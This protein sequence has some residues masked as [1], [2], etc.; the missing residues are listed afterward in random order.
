[1]TKYLD[2]LSNDFIEHSLF[3]VPSRAFLTSH[4]FH[5]FLFS[6]HHF[7]YSS[8]M[9]FVPLYPNIC[10][11]IILLVFF[12]YNT[13]LFGQNLPVLRTV[14]VSN[15]HYESFFLLSGDYIQD[16]QNLLDEYEGMG[17]VDYEHKKDIM[18]IGATVYNGECKD[19]RPH[20]VFFISDRCLPASTHTVRLGYHCFV[21][22]SF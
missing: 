11:N 21:L 7:E 20:L 3:I 2:I 15:T 9:I 1:M 19:K 18:N 6:K 16:N 10:Y 4:F 12:L 8:Y 13:I 5:H 17:V 22:Y 14:P